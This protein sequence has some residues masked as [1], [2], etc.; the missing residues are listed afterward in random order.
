M[1]QEIYNEGRVVGL[2]AWELYMREALGEGVSPDKIPSEREWLSSMIGSGASMVLRIPSGTAKGVQEFNL[3][4]N[5]DLSAAGVIIANPFMGTCDWDSSNWATKITSYSSLIQNNTTDSP[6]ADGSDVPYNS[7]YSEQECASIVSQFMKI[8]DG[9]VYTKNAY[10][11]STGSTPQKDIDP[12]FNESSAVVRLYIDADIT[13]DTYVLLTGFTNKRV[14][15]GLS[16]HAV[17]EG[18]VSKGGSTD[19]LNN[20]WADGGMLGPE[21][22]PW[23]SKIVFSVPSS[24]YRIAS[25]LIRTI[26]SDSTYTIPSGGLTIDGIKINENAVDGD[27]RPS[28]VI[29]YNAINL[30]DYY[31]AHGLTGS[32]LAENISAGPFDLADN[33]NVVTAWYPGMTAAKVDEAAQAVTPSNE[34]F[35][36]PAIFAVQATATGSQYL[37]PLDTAAPGTV[38]CF[39]DVDDATNYRQLMPNNYTFYYDTTNNLVSFVT[40]GTINDWPGMAKITYL[41]E[42][43][44]AEIIAS[45][46]SAQ[47]I[48]LTNSSGTAYNTAG[49]GGDLVIGPSGKPNWNNLLSALKD[50]KSLDVLGNKLRNLG[51]ELD[52]TNTIGIT[53]AVTES[54]ANKLTI[55]GTNAVSMTATANM[56]TNLATLGTNQSIKSGTNFIE[57]SNGLRLYI[58]GTEPG[59]TNVPT[60]S[61]GIGW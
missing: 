3:P 27:V 19:I 29:D 20:D 24:A 37:V 4:S 51:V 55:T 30:T 14:L 43:P 22:F 48:A 16:G 50:N 21:I 57:F 10:W 26:P 17:L 59:T 23:A 53:N 5:S 18:G 45:N 56:G 13:S 1:A 41:Q 44:K 7:D 39:T 36:P 8:T 11:I 42:A 46:K 47:F 28:S 2:S 33:V 54:G 35:F 15:Q 31:V 38:K 49:S 6:S 52:T 58:S 32:L 61:I 12:N 40:S 34:N 9:I 60:G 25:S